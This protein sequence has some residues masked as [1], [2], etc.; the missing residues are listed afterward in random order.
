MRTKINIISWGVFLIL[1]NH[2]SNEERPMRYKSELRKVKI[3]KVASKRPSR[4][5]L[6]FFISDKT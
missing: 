3:E 6:P 1:L 5:Q 4:H 2:M